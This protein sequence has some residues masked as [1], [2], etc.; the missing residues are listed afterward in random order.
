MVVFVMFL[1]VP[2][3][4]KISSGIGKS[5]LELVA[6]DNA[7]SSAGISNYNLVR[8]SSVLPSGCIQENE[9]PL[10]YGSILYTAYGSFA[11]NISDQTIASAV[12]IAVPQN[13][14]IGIIMEHAGMCR[15]SEARAIVTVM[16]EEAMRNHGIPIKHIL[17]SSIEATTE[18]N[19]F[20]TVISAVT[21]W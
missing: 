12:S 3:H 14:E 19:V 7:L 2:S 4:F 17:C 13:D 8:V 10:K 20:F 5:R 1:P 21:M 9:V 11:S 6:F 16:A 15:E 18:E